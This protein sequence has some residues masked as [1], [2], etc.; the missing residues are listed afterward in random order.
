MVL[1]R[2][3]DADGRDAS[4]N[5]RGLF[6]SSWA[7]HFQVLRCAERLRGVRVWNTNEYTAVLISEKSGLAVK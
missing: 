1:K 3:L 2:E 7:G 5:G 4:D 6:H